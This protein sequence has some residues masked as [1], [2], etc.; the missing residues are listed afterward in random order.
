[1]KP[2]ATTRPCASIT[3]ASAG[4]LIRPR[5]PTATIESP[6]MMTT[7]SLMGAR[8]EPSIS[9]APVIATVSTGL[10]LLSV[11]EDTRLSP[12]KAEKIVTKMVEMAMTRNRS[13]QVLISDKASDMFFGALPIKRECLSFQVSEYRL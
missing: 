5:F 4:I 13:D 7:V 11:T 1:M 9:V 2:G 6:L 3:L 8:P 10:E 12:T